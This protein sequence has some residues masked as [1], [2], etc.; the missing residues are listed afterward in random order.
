MTRYIEDLEYVEAILKKHK[1]PYCDYS[2]HQP[3]KKKRQCERCDFELHGNPKDVAY[4]VEEEPFDYTFKIDECPECGSKDLFYETDMKEL[5][6]QN[7]KCGLV[8]TGIHMY[9]GYMK[10]NYP[11]GL[12]TNPNFFL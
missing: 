10:I 12:H 6:C 11:F 9:V 8:L 1:C 4:K 7:P 2:L 5:V 3:H